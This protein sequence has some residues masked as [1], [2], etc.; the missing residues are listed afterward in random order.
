MQPNKYIIHTNA[1]TPRSLQ[2]RRA[3]VVCFAV[4]QRKRVP[5]VGGR[6]GRANVDADILHAV[7]VLHSA[8]ELLHTH[9]SL[10][11]HE[12]RAFPAGMVHEPGT[13]N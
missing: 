12:L 10:R 7:P 9:L 2:S 1:R 8:P 5:E 6:Y 11:L 3:A 13:P 4:P